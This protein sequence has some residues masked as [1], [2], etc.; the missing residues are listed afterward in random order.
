[1]SWIERLRAGVEWSQSRGEVDWPAVESLLEVRL[2]DSY[3][4]YSEA[5]GWGEFNGA[6]EVFGAVADFSD[7][8]I[9]GEVKKRSELSEIDHEFSAMYAPYSIFPNS[10][11]LLIW[12][13]TGRGD[14]LFWDT[15]NSGA[16][17]WPI[18]AFLD[19]GRYFSYEMEV[20]EF[21]FGCVVT[22]GIESFNA[23]SRG[24]GTGFMPISSYE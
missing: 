17:D 5:F 21:L 19:D 23:V 13:V 11:G 8:G 12:G 3:K 10:G 15:R 6:I 16:A 4:E 22:G 18:V 20:S 1:M 9:V 7:G 24:Y 14:A 2:P